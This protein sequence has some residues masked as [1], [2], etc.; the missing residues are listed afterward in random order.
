MQTVIGIILL[1]SFFAFIY[2]AAKGGN[3][4]LG[5]F[6]MAI[7]WSA[8]GAIGG[9][10]DWKTFNNTII[11][12]GPEGFGPTAVN[13]M[14]GSWFGRILIETGIARTIIRKAVELGGDKPTLTT[15]LLCIVVAGIFTTAYGAGAVV[16]G[17][18]E[19]PSKDPVIIG[20]NVLVG[21]N[22]V[23]LEGVKIGS[24]SVVAAGSVVVSDV[25]PGVV[26]AGTPAKI[27]KR[28]DTKT[29]NKTQLLEDLRK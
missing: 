5:L 7:L 17:V 18:L 10:V 2:Y 23:I 6:S 14:F 28:V 25:E 22:A 3:M 20:D 29:K 8:L 15:V 24:G 9:S 21:A 26:V 12:G 16:A 13:I 1:I 4:L 27:V 19:P 11:Q